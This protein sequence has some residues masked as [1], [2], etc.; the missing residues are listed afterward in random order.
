MSTQNWRKRA[1]STVPVPCSTVFTKSTVRT[2]KNNSQGVLVDCPQREQT[3]YTADAV[4]QGLNIFYNFKNS[5]IVRK[6]VYDLWA[7]R[8]GSGNLRSR[9]PSEGVQEIPE[10]T[11]HWVMALWHP[12]LLL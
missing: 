3:Q 12:V 1:T 5:T 2:Q 7:S 6:C 9:H 10:W 8:L 4:I 11:F